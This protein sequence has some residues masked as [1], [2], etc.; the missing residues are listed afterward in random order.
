MRVH[1]F[2]YLSEA[3]KTHFDSLF[4]EIW[5]STIEEIMKLVSIFPIIFDQKIISSMKVEVTKEEN[6]KLL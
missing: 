5:S 6:Y 1:S 4:K 3:V 2:E